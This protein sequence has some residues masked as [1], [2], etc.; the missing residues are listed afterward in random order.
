MQ[1]KHDKHKHLATCMCVTASEVHLWSVAT[2]LHIFFCY[3]KLQV[4]VLQNKHNLRMKTVST[5]IKVSTVFHFQI[6]SLKYGSLQ[7][8]ITNINITQENKNKRS[9]YTTKLSMSVLL[10][11]ILSAGTN[12][13]FPVKCLQQ[14]CCKIICHLSQLNTGNPTKVLFTWHVTTR[15]LHWNPIDL[16][17]TV[18]LSLLL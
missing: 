3:K 2:L 17:I 7:Y 16:I 4:M 8:F 13:I 18:L 9:K 12:M 5:A 6:T 10:K 14:H 11:H 1:W 15:R